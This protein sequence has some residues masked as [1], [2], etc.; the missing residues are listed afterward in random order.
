MKA[1]KPGYILIL[2]FF[3]IAISVVLI[4]GV[5]KQASN[6]QKNASL[7]RNKEKAKLLALSGIQLALDE[8]S[9]IEDQPV[10][11]DA[12]PAKPN[13]KEIQAFLAKWF[14][15][16][17]PAVNKWTTVSLTD[18]LFG[19][20]GYIK[21]FISCEQGKIDLNNF[22]NI[23]EKESKQ[24]AEPVKAIDAEGKTE[25]LSSQDT[26]KIK[27]FTSVVDELVKKEFKVDLIATLKEAKNFIPLEDP[28][29]LLKYKSFESVKDN[30]FLPLNGNS[31][32]KK[33]PVTL[34]DLFTTLPGSGKLNPWFLSYSM[35]KILG[36]QRKQNIKLADII[37]Q[38]KPKMDWEKEWDKTL[39]ELYGKQFNSMPKEITSMFSDECEATAFSVIVYA[40]VGPITQRL[41][42]ILERENPNKMSRKNI[43]FKIAKIFWF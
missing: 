38:F 24:T 40:K 14:S 34:M 41:Y 42:A 32:D 3:F 5:L 9:L 28:T 2:T 23:L 15:G 10:E 8:I 30:V 36:L 21:Y 16:A 37:K 17:F 35:A 18:E 22:A 13:E 33:M 31:A 20:D 12:K 25:T 4:T 6:F 1:N 27:S 11:D 19:V 29:Q 39:A 7:M 26:S 43:V